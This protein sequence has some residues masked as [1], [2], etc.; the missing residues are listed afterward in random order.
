MAPESGSNLGAVIEAKT[1]RR[2]E[3]NKDGRPG[4]HGQ[5]L[6]WP[7]GKKRATSAGASAV[8]AQKCADTEDPALS[9]QSWPSS[10]FRLQEDGADI[11]GETSAVLQANGAWFLR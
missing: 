10:D 3:Q 7:A 4:S 11:F 8:L 9:V 1:L 2:A 6:A 5:S